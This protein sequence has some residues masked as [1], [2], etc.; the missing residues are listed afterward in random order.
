MKELDIREIANLSGVTPSALRFYEKKGLITPVGRNGL[1][2]QYHENVLNKLQ[3]IGLGQAAGF[4]LDEMATMFNT[5]GKV[6]IDR[7]LLHQRAKE[8]DNTIRRLQLLSRGLK[9]AA[10]CT[11][12][13]HTQCEEFKKIVSRGLRL[14][15]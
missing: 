7:E 10:R 12:P 2:R 15:R 13:E 4:S 8:I 11:E 14:L 5:E 1:R 3:L 9:H 6:A